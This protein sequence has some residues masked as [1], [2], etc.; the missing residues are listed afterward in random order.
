MGACL[1]CSQSM[2][3]R[4]DKKFCSPSCRVS[5]HYDKRQEEDTFFFEVEKALRTNRKILKRYNKNGLS[6]LRKSLLIEEGFN[7]NYFTHYWKNQKGETYLFVY[8]FGFRAIK[9]HKNIDKYLLVKWQE[10]MRS[11]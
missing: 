8:E 5:Y 11:K 9:D 4:K 3:G 6:T 2:S 10:Y 1:N 7:P